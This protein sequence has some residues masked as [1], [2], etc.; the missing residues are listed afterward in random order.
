[1]LKLEKETKRLNKEI[2]MANQTIVF[3]K[4]DIFQAHSEAIVN[5]V[6]CVGVMGRGL[7]LEFKRKF[8]KNFQEYKTAC[9]KGELV[10]GKLFITFDES[11]NQHIV[12]FPTKRH[13]REPSKLEDIRQGLAALRQ[14]IQKHNIQ[15][16]A[17]PALGC[18]LGGLAW[19]AVKDEII[20][21]LQGIDCQ[22]LVFEP[23]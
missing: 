6:N 2:K 19:Q 16:I 7:A 13:W 11:T 5:A 8:P 12:N 4:G 10:I 9:D 20:A 18:G 3:K 15:S 14:A 22:V 23:L 21:A 1:M 17:I